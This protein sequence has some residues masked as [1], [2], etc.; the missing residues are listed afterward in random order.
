ML[1]HYNIIEE[2]KRDL[3]DWE[4]RRNKWKSQEKEKMKKEERKRKHLRELVK[5]LNKEELV[6]INDLHQPSLPAWAN[7]QSLLK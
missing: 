2:W 7:F 3:K 1:G 5:S 6:Q 4:E